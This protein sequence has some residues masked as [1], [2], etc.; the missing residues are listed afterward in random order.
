MTHEQGPDGSAASSRRAARRFA[1]SLPAHPPFLDGDVKQ[2]GQ[3]PVRVS[4]RPRPQLAEELVLRL[5]PERPPDV[6]DSPPFP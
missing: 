1:P 4:P 3:P 6:Q 5:C 2:V